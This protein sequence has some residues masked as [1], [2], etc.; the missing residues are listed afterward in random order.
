[1]NEPEVRWDAADYAEHSAAQEIWAREM[2]ERLALRGDEH[3]LDIGSG[4]GKVTAR[5]AARVPEGRQHALVEAVTD[6]YLQ[7]HPPEEDGSVAVHMVR[8][9]VEA[10][11]CEPG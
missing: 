4:D 11:R 9:E 2:L 6:A 7:A 5:I 3:V 1:M 8:L 10:T